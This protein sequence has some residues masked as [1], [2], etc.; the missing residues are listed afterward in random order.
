MWFVFLVP[1]PTQVGKLNPVPE[2]RTLGK[3][4]DVYSAHVFVCGPPGLAATADAACL[5]HSVSF[6][7]EV[8]AF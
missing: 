4:K 5:E 3:H 2:I 6:H 1:P 7:K 8:F